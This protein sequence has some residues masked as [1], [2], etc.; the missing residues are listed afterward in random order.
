[1]NQEPETL[2]SPSYPNICDVN[3]TL[4]QRANNGTQPQNELTRVSAVH[5]ACARTWQFSYT[6]AFMCETSSI[7]HQEN[8]VSANQIRPGFVF[9]IVNLNHTFSLAAKHYVCVNFVGLLQHSFEH[10]KTDQ[11]IE[12]ERY[13]I[14]YTHHTI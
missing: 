6:I 5:H 1:M 13:Y 7:K 12:Y 8:R 2:Y 10:G 3:S 11:Y 4:F 14:L 9:R